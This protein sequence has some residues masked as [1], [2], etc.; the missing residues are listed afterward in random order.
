MDEGQTPQSQSQ[1]SGDSVEEQKPKQKSE[2][3]V[4][5]ETPAGEEIS[6]DSEGSGAQEEEDQDDDDDFENFT[7]SEIVTVYVGVKR[8]RFFL[9]RELVCQRSPFMEKCLKKGHFDEGYK[10]ELYLPEDD[11]KAFSI[12]VDWI[13]RSRLPSRTEPSFDVSDMS[14]AYCMADK[15]GM[16]ELQNN[17]ID[18]VRANFS[19]RENEPCKAPNFS[20]LAL[21][22]LTGPPKSP[23]KRF[24]VEHL[25]H[26]MMRHPKWYHD[27]KRN[28]P[29]RVDMEELFKI[30]DLVFYV[31]K[32]IWQF[33]AEPWKDPATW[34]KC[35]YHVHSTTVCAARAAATTA[36]NKQQQP[37]QNP[38]ASS[39]SA[40][41]VH[42]YSLRTAQGAWPPTAIGVWNPGVGW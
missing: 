4:E 28:E 14:A 38:H 10:N 9:H 20:A 22:H 17:I 30:P 29:A 3:D 8:K 41:P 34:D 27:L 15:F 33:Q 26:H 16:E 35:C 31:M 2:A 36:R 7:T 40:G 42:G 13:Y 32:K 18:N 1:A 39:S 12:V 19:R 6:A 11:P 25:V 21:T 5:G 23:L 37:G 24:Y